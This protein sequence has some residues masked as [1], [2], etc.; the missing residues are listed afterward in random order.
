[1]SDIMLFRPNAAKNPTGRCPLGL[2][3]IATPLVKK[4]LKVKLIDEETCQYWPIEL[5]NN[6]TPST[7]CAG[8][9]V[10]TGKSIKSALEF[11]KA[12]KKVRQIP[13][14]WGGIHPSILPL[15]T[16]RSDSVDIVV[17][18][19]GERKFSAI[20]DQIRNKKDLN[21]IKGIAFKEKGKICQTEPETEFLDLNDL[22]MPDFSLI[23]V[24]Y[25]KNPGS[26]FLS[27]EG[28]VLDL[29]VDRGCPY[30]CAF[31][32]NLRFNSRRWRAIEAEKVIAMIESLKK[33]HNLKAIN[34]VSDNFFV[35]KKRVY[36]FCKGII[37]RK[38]DIAWHADMRIDTFLHF[39]NNLIELIKK[40]G[41]QALT[42]GV[43]SGSD[44]I[45]KLIDKD[46]TIDNVFEAHRKAIS[47]GFKINYHFM[48]GFPEETKQDALE[49]IKIARILTRDKNVNV[50]GP[51]M[52]VPYPGTPLYDRCCELGF[53]PPSRL[54][55]WIDYD[56]SEMSKLPWFSNDFKNYLS[57]VQTICRG[58]IHYN[59]KK[60]LKTYLAYL[61]CRLR[62]IGLEHGIRL[63]DLD[64]KLMR[65]VFSKFSIR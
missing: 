57:E 14:I 6:M 53:V 35:D 19:E 10:M 11:S 24:E 1:M 52:Y 21:E 7:I 64:T 41:C 18:G 9:S 23:D 36:K 47:F 51:S 43:E 3:Y 56:F 32:Y 2:V 4:G 40:S 25:Y 60:N 48:I 58:G 13:I 55:D 59:V 29:N 44:R 46:I 26:S 34:L 61:Y 38:I 62:L 16:L 27:E 54:E 42:F 31:C 39:E 33:E 15:E 8:V 20:V 63:L 5:R 22:P 65:F 50:Y 12:L 17:I 28:G 30:R 45:L 37:E 49:T